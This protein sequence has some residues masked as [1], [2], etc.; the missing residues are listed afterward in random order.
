M[1]RRL[2]AEQDSNVP[3][4]AAALSGSIMRRRLEAEQ[5]SNAGAKYG[6][7]YEAS[8][9]GALILVSVRPLRSLVVMAYHRVVG[10][11]TV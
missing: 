11:G 3:R 10:A 6:A 5:D 7:R 1:R 9:W 8:W 2:E 4:S